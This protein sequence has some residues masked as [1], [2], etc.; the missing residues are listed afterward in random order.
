MF[1][2]KKVV[3][4][5]RS[6]RLDNADTLLGI[7]DNLPTPVFVKD[8]QLRFVFVNAAHCRLIGKTENELLGHSDLD[9]Y[10]S[11]EAAIF[12]AGERKVFETGIASVT[13]ERVALHDGSKMPAITRKSKYQAPD[14]KTY[15]VGSNFDLTE[16]KQREEQYRV[17]AETVPVGVIQVNQ[18]GAIK[19]TNQLCL[20]LLG[21]D[22]PPAS[23]AD[24]TRLF[25]VIQP[26]FPGQAQ[27]FE[28]N[29]KNNKGLVHRLMVISSGWSQNAGKAEKSATISF[30]DIPEIT[31]LRQSAE[32]NSSHLSEIVSQTKESVTSISLSTKQ[33]NRG[34]A[35][36]SQQTERQMTDFEEMTTAIRQLAETLKQNF[37]HTDRANK[38]MLKA[39]TVAEDGSKMSIST[40]TAMSNIKESSQKIVS[41]VD[42]VQEIAFQTSLLALNAAVEAARAGTAGRG[43]AVVAAEVR[44]LAHRSAIALKEVRGHIQDSN[45]Q[46][47]QGV[48]LVDAMS[49]K[50]IEISTTT[51]EA[52]SLVHKI[53]AAGHEQ[54][55]AIHQVD[56]SVVKLES[57]A[58]ANVK[59][60][61]QFTSSVGAVDQSMSELKS[62]IEP[63]V[64]KAA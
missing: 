6:K 42:L 49:T 54:S 10:K 17:L 27:K 2:F 14:G 51:K 50:L 5:Q 58:F 59:L 55:T 38:L 47:S 23:I 30:V 35:F 9:F 13:E 53:A 1:R 20:T 29:I 61:E 40:T 21:L 25:T 3:A 48:Q 34:A 4:K 41:I 37:V 60:L 64:M 44:T 43:F 11:E 12:M 31:A 56:D 57:A 32:Q 63:K 62:L 22:K 26:D 16:I 45:V 52:T 33:L 15:L 7:L 24:I 18:S 8:D 36:L 28:V 39:A 46:V 19:F